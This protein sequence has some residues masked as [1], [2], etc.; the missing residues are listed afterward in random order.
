MLMKHPLIRAPH[1]GLME[2]TPSS[3]KVVSTA[4]RLDTIG[5]IAIALPVETILTN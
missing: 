5:L 4:D 3:K 1:R 2:V